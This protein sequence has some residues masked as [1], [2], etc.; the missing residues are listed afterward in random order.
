MRD[1]KRFLKE[2][3]YING[4]WVSAQNGKTF[5][6]RNPFNNDKIIEVPDLGK[7]ET[8]QAIVS[9]KVALEKW[10]NET[11]EYRAR[12]LKKLFNLQLDFAD[13]LAYILTLEQGK[14]LSEA[15][16]EIKYGASFIEWFAEEGRRTYGETIPSNASDK[17]V[18]TIK[19]PV[20]VVAAITPW[21]FPNAMITRKIAP[22]LAA[23]CTVVVKPA[24][25]TP[26]SALAIAVLAEM[27]G[28]PKGV[29]NIIT[30][31][32]P[33]EVGEELTSNSIVKKISFTG[34]THVGKILMKQCAETV[35]KVS[36]ELGGNAPFIVFNDADIDSAV[37]GVIASKFRNSGQ[38]CVCT[39]RIFVHDSIYDEFSYKLSKEVGKLKI[40]NG[41][42]QGIAIGPLINEKAVSF[43]N[44]L[45]ED[46]SG[47][48]AEVI[49]GGNLN[50]LGGNFF[51]PTILGN[52]SE[53]MDVYNKEIFGSIAPLIRFTKEEEVIAMANNTPYGLASYFFS[54]D[55]ARVWRV[56][57][58]LDY[59]MVGVNT[60]K[61]ST[62][63]APFGGVKESG[64]GREGSK[65]GIEE[66]LEIKYICIGGL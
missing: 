64:I 65:Y 46:A 41:I 54:K 7:E 4:K 40:G 26:L 61:I 20:G 36:M 39:N 12:L 25:S 43:L 38:T 37:E 24:E 5:E 47:K 45:V 28:I 18:L 60:G 15:Q 27:A 9:A 33:I 19:Q 59:G 8:I 66:Y 52:V 32:K 23:G 55:Y 57:E 3:A 50:K 49:I 48:G 6:V 63:V 53:E 13:E 1:Y 29:I 58:G 2:K 51:P 35:K 11:A 30:T 31:N 21:N 42:E 17:R 22:A 34:S 10:K 16:G 62:T 14:P 44:N 56:S